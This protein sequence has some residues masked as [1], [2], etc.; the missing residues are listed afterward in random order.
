MQ[1]PLIANER[2][3]D[4]INVQWVGVVVD[5]SD[6][7]MTSCDCQAYLQ[8]LIAETGVAC[9]CRNVTVIVPEG[10]EGESSGGRVRIA[11]A[12][13]VSAVKALHRAIRLAA[14][15]Q[16]HLAV[17]LGPLLPGNEVLLDLVE[18]FAADPMFGTVQ[19]RFADS[20][21][22][23]IWALPSARREAD[24]H[25][26]LRRSSIVLLPRRCITPEFLSA[27]MV[28]RDRLLREM[29]P[30]G[31]TDIKVEL[32]SLLERARRRGFRNIVV[33]HKV[34]GSHLGP[35]VVYPTI[36]SENRSTSRMHI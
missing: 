29:E 5:L 3:A 21:S 12:K 15:M 24:S 33:N 30:S 2:N 6:C 20:V 34:I 36:H 22:D 26:K 11:K 18:E 13:G 4:C 17:V 7:D 25:L 23:G 27:C 10:C 16:R 31:A 35:E 14:L 1:A 9:S 32:I 8:S 28:I 19:P